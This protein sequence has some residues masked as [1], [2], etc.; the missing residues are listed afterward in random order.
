M[1]LGYSLT[2]FGHQASA[3][4]DGA[5]VENLGFDALLSQVAS[6]ENAGFD[7]VLL[8]DRLGA[9]PLDDLSPVATPFEPTTLVAALATR[10]ARI[11]F[12]AAASTR[13]H[14]PYNLARRFASLDSISKGRSGWLALAAP[15]EFP[16]DREYLSLVSALWDS[17]EDDAFVYDKTEGRFFQPDK[18]HV[19]GHRGEYFAVRGPLNVNRS[20][21]GK[22]VVAQMLGN[23]NGVL[24][25]YAADLVLL[26]SGS[27]AGAAEAVGDFNRTLEAVGRS[28][29][30]VRLLA[31]VIPFVAATRE[32]AQALHDRLQASATADVGSSLGAIL[33]GT[34][35]EMADALHTWFKASGLDGFTI[36]PPSLAAA[37]TF[38]NDV[39]PRL[40]RPDPVEAK[41]AGTLRDRLGLNRPPHPATRLEHAS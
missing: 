3:W 7:F 25:A 26:Q 37:E 4:R 20:P 21:Q 34:P 15:G 9:R 16:R 17:W 27:P 31:N 13:Q 22:P 12:L 32:K 29:K 11:G 1:R 2:P 14:E 18:M 24:A 19:L 28:R 8:S 30:Q 10:T 35:D 39:A 38:V 33:I 36:L 23:E 41:P 6:A 5:T 40:R